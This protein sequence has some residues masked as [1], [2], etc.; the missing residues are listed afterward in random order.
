[1]NVTDLINIGRKD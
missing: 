1:M